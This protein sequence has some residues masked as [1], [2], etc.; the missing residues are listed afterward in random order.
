MLSNYLGLATHLGVT[1]ESREGLDVTGAVALARRGGVATEDEQVALVRKGLERL[2]VPCLLVFDDVGE[3]ALLAKLF[4][5]SGKCKV[6]VTSRPN[7]VSNFHNIP[8]GHLAHADCLTLLR[9]SPQPGAKDFE[10]D[11]EALAEKFDYLTLAM[12]VCSAWLREAELQ[13]ADL[14]RRLWD[15]ESAL[16]FEGREVDPDFEKNPDLIALFKASIEQMKRIPHGELAERLILV[17]GWFEGS[18]VRTELMVSAARMAASDE[19]ALDDKRV[20]KA[21]Y[22][23][24]KFNLANRRPLSCRQEVRASGVMF[25]SVTRSFGRVSGGREFGRAMVAALAQTG[26]ATLDTDHFGNACDLALPPCS[27]GEPKLKLDTGHRQ[28]AVAKVLLPLVNHYMN[29]GLY[30]RARDV[31]QDMDFQGITDELQCKCLARWASCLEE[32]GDYDGAL[33]LLEQAFTLIGPGHRLEVPV[34]NNMAHVL[35][36]QGKYDEALQLYQ[37]ALHNVEGW[38]VSDEISKAMIS[39]NMAGILEDQ[40]KFDEALKLYEHNLF[41]EERE[42][43]PDNPAIAMTLCGTGRLLAKQSKYEEAQLLLE[44]GQ[45]IVEKSLGPDHPKMAA[46]L[47]NMAGLLRE[48]GKLAEAMPLLQRALCIAEK[49]WG[50]EHP[51]VADIVNNMARLSLG[52][53]ELD[54]AMLLYERALRIQEQIGTGAP[55]GVNDPER[56]GY[57]I[58]E[59]RQ[60]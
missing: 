3:V 15:E 39:G 52:L 50:F 4:P 34:L 45:C 14:L 23:L 10:A 21:V 11:L 35:Q 18:P 7:L 30:F 47:D 37:K 48:Q 44:R 22:V 5:R 43:G 56:Y 36:K 40:G 46:L 12:S 51:S 60:V 6:L 58:A 26:D 57:D 29:E 54:E 16:A 8:L 1:L 28:G 24:V 9:N 2:E 19:E 41:I 49:A 13:P 25:H 42:W 59:A 31:I 33:S 20:E 32:C 17:G 38:P 55:V 27:L 53:G